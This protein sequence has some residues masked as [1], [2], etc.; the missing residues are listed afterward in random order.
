MAVPPVPN[1]P[2]A[3]NR[4]RPSQFADEAEVYLGFQRTFV[5]YLNRAAN[6]CD[7]RASHVIMVS[8]IARLAT[9]DFLRNNPGR[10]I[11]VNSGGSALEGYDRVP[12]IPFASRAEALAGLINTKSM[13]P[14]RSREA[15]EDY[16]PR[17]VGWQRIATK[18]ASN[19]SR[20]DFGGA[21]FSAARY[22]DY[23]FVLRNVLPATDG[24]DFGVR[25][26]DD[27]GSSGTSWRMA[28]TSSSSWQ[29]GLLDFATQVGTAVDETG[30]SGVLHVFN[31]H[32]DRSCMFTFQ[33]TYV[34]RSASLT[35]IDLAGQFQRPSA[36]GPI[37][38]LRFQASGGNIDQGEITLYGLIV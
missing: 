30:V 27:G 24:V 16:A 14:L 25:P 5:D 17:V 13:S 1:I 20:L 9:A 10:L 22:T 38:H 12:N 26:S 7:E 32:E 2:V 18:R 28:T 21:D 36:D 37:N 23:Q 31:L 35:A 4:G 3:P 33:G 29:S 11:G 6:F 34:N 19:S 8:A 15:I